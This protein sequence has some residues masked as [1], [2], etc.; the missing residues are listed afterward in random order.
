MSKFLDDYKPKLLTTKEA[1]IKSLPTTF[2][3]L[4][5][6]FILIKLIPE[7]GWYIKRHTGMIVIGLFAIWRY[8]WQVTHVVR[9]LKYRR[10]YFPSIR[11]QA[12]ALEDKYPGR[13]FFVIPS[14]F[15]MPEITERVFRSIMDECKDLTCRS[16]MIVIS[17]GS[18]E[19]VS[20][21]NK[22]VS[23]EY[24]IPNMK[25]TFMIQKSGKRIAMG[26]A[27]RAV[28]REYNRLDD[29]DEDNVN[30][31]V[32]LMDGDSML[33]EGILEKSLPI[34]KL[35]PNLGIITPNN[36][37]LSTDPDGIFQTWYELKFMQRNHIFQSHSLS[38]RFL[39]ATGRF[40]IYRAPIVI[41]DEFI[42]FVETDYLDHWIFGRFRFL[43]GDDKSTWFYCLKEGYEMLYVPDAHIVAIEGRTEKF[44]KTSVGL[45]TRWYGNTLRNNKRAVML[46]SEK[47]GFFIWWC[48]VDQR[49]TTW[50]PLVGLFSSIVLSVFHSPFYLLFYIIWVLMIR[51]TYSWVYV[52]QGLHLKPEH[53]L[54]MV[55]TQWVGAFVKLI[56]TYNL[57]KQKWG[58][59]D[60]KEVLGGQTIG[61]FELVQKGIRYTMVVVNIVGLLLFCG[62]STNTLSM[63]SLSYFKDSSYSPAP[64]K[65][66]HTITIN[67]V[68]LG[69]I[70]DD[71]LPD[72]D[73]INKAIQSAD[74]HTPTV[75]QLPEGVFILKKPIII[76]KS[77]ISLVGSGSGSTLLKST[78]SKDEGDGV[79]MING[80]KGIHLGS[81]TVDAKKKDKRLIISVDPKM[82]QDFEN[83]EYLWLGTANTREFLD[84]I[85]ADKWNRQYPWLR[86]TIVKLEDYHGNSARLKEP[87]SLNLPGVNT[88]V[89]APYM[90]KNVSV[91]G[92]SITQTA[93]DMKPSMANGIYKN[94]APAYA[95]DGISFNRAADSTLEDIKVTYAGRHPV[96]VENSY[97][98]AM[99]SL[100]IQGSWNKGEGGNGYFRFA[101]SYHCS[102]EN[103]I[104]KDVRHLTFQW[105]AAENSVKNCIMNVDVNFH[106]GYSHHNTVMG[107]DI[108][109]SK[110]HPWN[111]VTR[112]PKGGA[113]YA[114]GDGEE[115]IVKP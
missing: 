100:N 56:T 58:K 55:Y 73:A 85:G 84:K 17:V 36:I 46:G 6:I 27:L 44:F 59:G 114:P 18:Q 93:D 8:L 74:G 63:P 54:L 72:D 45:M 51:L 107:C 70:A 76:N 94:I 24:Y 53:I 67:A 71:D 106:G 87:L 26:H 10:S 31:L 88:E 86:Q 91:K 69:A 66:T 62:F 41:T 29:W 5:A 15:E 48:L 109:P 95:V 7:E 78:F 37:A 108:K 39:T 90:V 105:S 25:I 60:K 64:P 115:N 13:L 42:Q 104:I 68:D 43:M 103:S 47:M 92:L 11:K 81:L 96:S 14:Y 33:V 77:N 97:G 3:Y 38:D 40:C 80:D 16:I 12:D 79:I 111:K 83:A 101:R 35:K 21:I 89:Y 30:D 99:K 22:I 28:A 20:N 2:V 32:V 113:S 52:L 102:L 9:M 49:L 19:E 61:R 82:Q 57:K 50:T 110:K 98:I 1:A 65:T 112:M 23:E 75:I 34:F 4:L